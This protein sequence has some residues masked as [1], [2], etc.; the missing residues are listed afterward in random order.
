MPLFRDQNRQNTYFL[1]SKP[2]VAQTLV[3]AAPRLVS[4]LFSIRRVRQLGHTNLHPHQPFQIPIQMFLRR[5]KMIAIAFQP[6]HH[7]RPF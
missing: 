6:A 4:A 1:L 2:D 5:Q 3:F 7:Q